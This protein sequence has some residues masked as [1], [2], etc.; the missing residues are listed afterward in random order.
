[1]A[2]V[3]YSVNLDDINKISHQWADIIVVPGQIFLHWQDKD[4]PFDDRHFSI[5]KNVVQKNKF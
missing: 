5:D 1:V 2:W 4:I 3:F